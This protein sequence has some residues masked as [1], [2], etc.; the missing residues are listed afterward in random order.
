MVNYLLNIGQKKNKT[1]MRHKN[2]YTEQT[3]HLENKMKNKK[4]FSGNFLNYS[5]DKYL[6][7]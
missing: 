1:M 4:M 7:L 6:K 5:V 3:E 2:T